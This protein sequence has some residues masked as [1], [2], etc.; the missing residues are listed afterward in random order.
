MLIWRNPHQGPEFNIAVGENRLAYVFG[1]L[2]RNKPE[3]APLN[4]ASRLLSNALANRLTDLEK[5]AATASET[6]KSELE[7]R[8]ASGRGYLER[9]RQPVESK[10]GL[11]KA[12]LEWEWLNDR[13][14]RLDSETTNYLDLEDVSESEFKAFLD[15]RTLGEVAV[16]SEQMRKK[17]QIES[18][19]RPKAPSWD[20]FVE[21]AE[22]EW[23]EG[24]ADVDDHDDW[25]RNRSK[26]LA[27]QAW[28]RPDLI[29]E[30]P[31]DAIDDIRN[32]L[33]EAQFIIQERVADY[34][35]TKLQANRAK[36]E[37]L[38]ARFGK[39]F[40]DESAQELARN[41]EFY[42]KCLKDYIQLY[43][44][45]DEERILP[46]LTQGGKAIPDLLTTTFEGRVM[47]LNQQA[48][49]YFA[50]L[51]Q[52][53]KD[54][55]AFVE[56]P[57]AY[58]QNLEK[59][60][61]RLRNFF[62]FFD[63]PRFLP[64]LSRQLQFE[65]LRHLRDGTADEPW[66]S[67]YTQSRQL[68][69][70]LGDP[71]STV[72]ADLEDILN[73]SLKRIP[74]MAGEEAIGVREDQQLLL[75]QMASLETLAKKVDQNLETDIKKG[76]DAM[77]ALAAAGSVTEMLSA[78]RTK[79]GDEHIKEVSADEFDEYKIYT[80]T[81][82]MVFYQRGDEWK[83]IINKD[84][85]PTEADKEFLKDQLTHELRHLEFE[86][87][88]AV[89]LQFETAFEPG[90][91]NP[92]WLA[93]KNAFVAEFSAKKP[94]TASVTKPSYTSDD[95]EDADVLSELYAMRL[96]WDRHP[97][98]YS[99]ISASGALGELSRQEE[100]AGRL[101]TKISGYE[102][103]PT[104]RGAESAAQIDAKERAA[105]LSAEEIS[106]QYLLDDIANKHHKAQELK[107][108][109]FL[110]YVPS[111][112]ELLEAII[113]YL[114][115]TESQVETHKES[116]DTGTKAQMQEMLNHVKQD[117][118][119]I[120]SQISK[121]SE[122]IPNLSSNYLRVLWI[123]TNLISFSDIK[124][125][126]GQVKEYIDRW[127]KKTTAV[128]AGMLGMALFDE[129]PG[130]KGL[131][132]E[133]STNVSNA[134]KEAISKW[135]ERLQ[136]K[137][138][139]TLYNIIKEQS[140]K[141]IPDKNIVRACINVL[142][143]KQGALDWRN[144]Y[145]WRCLNKLQTAVYFDENDPLLKEDWNYLR[146]KL[147]KALAE[148][149]LYS[150]PQTFNK[151]EK[152]QSST[153]DSEVKDRVSGVKKGARYIMPRL[154]QLYHAF[155]VKEN[156]P[157]IDKPEY[158][159]LLEVSIKDGRAYPEYIMFYLII[160]MASGLLQP[161]RGVAL[162]AELLPIF[163]ILDWF[164]FPRTPSSQEGFIRLCQKFKEEFDA[165]EIGGQDSKFR[166][167]FWSEILNNDQLFSRM[168]QKATR[169]GTN[170]DHD[171]ARAAAAFGD[172]GMAKTLLHGT[173]N[174]ETQ[175][176]KTDNIYAGILQW[177]EMMAINQNKP[178]NWKNLLVRQIGYFAMY[179]SILCG[180][181]YNGEKTAYR[182]GANYN[183][184]PRDNANTFHDGW[185]V[186]QHRDHAISFIKSIDP[187]LNQ[188]FTDITDTP[189]IETNPD[190][191]KKVRDFI[192]PYIG[193]DIAAKITS[194]DKIYDHLEMI[195]NALCASIPPGQFEAVMKTRL[196]V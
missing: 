40:G 28:V 79:L 65:H 6:Q 33:L 130:G 11:E 16:A 157:P 190:H 120:T 98:L 70:Q 131:E 122:K 191:Y 45:A 145:I 64:A 102:G 170:I 86:K 9:I 69:E 133:S 25:I 31:Q 194:M 143:E 125:L 77:K 185:T 5:S 4:V 49:E 113:G 110:S 179:E 81:G 141:A 15:D 59:D 26:D 195:V 147:K 67:S 187:K 137:D 55:G 129:M 48:D 192:A 149:V 44:K 99:A 92:K 23:Q 32:K 154:Q 172:A 112:D 29:R 91:S 177:M 30:L 136:T 72:K 84:A 62:R 76:K 104:I 158:E 160:G 184:K 36:V 116:L 12:L 146:E 87:D 80:T 119:E 138:Y 41:N 164:T 135:E 105:E 151:L 152:K 82:Y 142:A 173:A 37:T 56:N 181:A 139:V 47:E 51:E 63:D 22:T 2:K 50:R 117:L 156:K 107:K 93:I 163:P 73:G 165:G 182:R 38:S 134:F 74:D 58:R 83:I 153:Y 57:N 196:K 189:E 27:K 96:E 109:P 186:G 101:S 97:A 17:R 155:T 121:A 68:I 150:N 176:T 24:K 132:L 35:K 14:L 34:L 175:T 118:N 75:S 169:G 171:W 71:Q 108:S 46:S 94:P 21:Q 78:I 89:R 174:D 167:F 85:I 52:M 53:E 90:E 61:L 115:T 178:G 166:K 161:D 1:F 13:F 144:I 66:L 183:N 126:F 43:D 140:E 95:W 123:G 159:A 111:A 124:T 180:A 42:E 103:A 3:K 18:A 39:D 100:S 106:A 19:I 162:S 60:D 168:R 193:P 7:G 148:K 188:F 88:A 8:L 54:H 114:T 20:D 127:R 128:N 10:E